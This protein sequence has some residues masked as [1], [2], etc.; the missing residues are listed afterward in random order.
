M[1]V[2]TDLG[3]EFGQVVHVGDELGFARLR[4]SAATVGSNARGLGCG[5]YLLETGQ[6][7][8]KIGN[9]VLAA[10]TASVWMHSDHRAV[11]P[12][13]D[14]P[15]AKD[16]PYFNGAANRRSDEQDCLPAGNG[17]YINVGGDGLDAFEIQP[18]FSDSL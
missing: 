7:K 9:R 3:K 17:S 18:P 12:P 4:L 16:L 6:F 13:L 8:F 1:V 10:P 2:S 11:V 14:I 5:H 15:G